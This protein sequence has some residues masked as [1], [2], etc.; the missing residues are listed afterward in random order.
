MLNVEVLVPRFAALL[1][2][3]RDVITGCTSAEAQLEPVEEKYDGV[4]WVGSF[5]AGYRSHRS[6]A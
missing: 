4:G 2:A 3:G 5:K 1:T 6:F